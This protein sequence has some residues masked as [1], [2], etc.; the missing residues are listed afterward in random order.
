MA[1]FLIMSYRDGSDYQYEKV[2]LAAR[3]K[4]GFLPG[5]ADGKPLDG[6][7]CYTI[8]H[9]EESADKLLAGLRGESPMPRPLDL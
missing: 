1:S 9:S 7:R 3:G 6:D 8:C 5:R 4:H 2:R